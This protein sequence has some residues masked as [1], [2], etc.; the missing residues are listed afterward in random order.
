[1]SIKSVI[2]S[3][4][5]KVKSG[6]SAK[7]SSLIST[8]EPPKEKVGILTRIGNVLSAFEPGAEI[9]TFIKTGDLG[10]TAK[11]YASET[12]RGLGSA[13]PFL[14][15]YTKPNEV[16]RNREGFREVLNALGMSKKGPWDDILGIAGDIVLDPGNLLLA[17]LFKTGA[18][19]L[20][21]A[22]KGLR[23][24]AE[25]FDVGRK[26]LGTGDEIAETIGRA[27]IPG[28]K[29]PE[30]YK[31]VKQVYK[32]LYE[33]EKKK[34]IDQ[35]VAFAKKLPDEKSFKNI[36]D[37][38]ETGGKTPIDEN[39]KPIAEEIKS[40]LL[41]IKQAEKSKG[42]LKKDIEYYFP[43]ILKDKEIVSGYKPL[44]TYLGAAKKRTKE[45]LLTEINEAMGKE[46]FE[47]NPAVAATLRGMASKKAISSRDFLETVEKSF[48][49]KGK[50][51]KLIDGVEYVPF[52]P[53][54][55]F[56]FYPVT[57]EAGKKVAGITKK[58]KTFL[59]PR[60]VADDMNKLMKSVNSPDEVNAMASLF[61]KVQNI[62]KTSVTSY[63]P[64]FHIR[65]A[66]SNMFVNWLAGVKDPMEYKKAF[67]VINGL[68]EEIA[69][70]KSGEVLDLAK[71]Y[72]VLGQG[73]FEKDL[74]DLFA[75]ELGKQGKVAEL[76]DL[77]RKAGT[78]IENN[79]RM[80]LFV[81]QLEK[82]IDPEKAAQTVKKYLFDYS[83][84]TDFEKS[85]M[86]RVFPF[87][88]WTRKAF[89]LMLDELVKQ[90][91][92]F[93]AVYD[94][95]RNLQ[96]NDLTEEEKMLI[97]EYMKNT[98]NIQIGRTDA[99]EPKFLSS[100][101]L[102][103][104]VLAKPGMT[105][106]TITQ[107]LS[108][109]LK[110]PLEQ[111]TGTSFFTKKKIKEDPFFYKTTQFM[112]NI[113]VLKQYLQAEE[114]E[115][116][117]VVNPQRMYWLKSIIGRFISTGETITKEDKEWIEKVINVLSGIKTYSFDAEEQRYFKEKEIESEQAQKLLRK[118]EISKFER[119]FVPKD[120]R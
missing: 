105:G 31:N 48:G 108:P 86:R 41:E 51:I 79:A 24:V 23:G 42:I 25:N 73:F 102:P 68:P 49:I 88:T 107:M 17:G 75:K 22:G 2:T 87:Y 104:E 103:M 92:K 20:K 50:D 82:G 36:V 47:S 69:G 35:G 1:M 46:F 67:N 101:G 99:G 19:G 14:D 3:S 93:K 117:W 61:D 98:F 9:K 43:H 64:S 32:D 33:Y 55:A 114:G 59:L 11:Q 80:T 39:I 4:K 71:R 89:P 100:L 90:P 40:Y 57:T 60:E 56:K 12:A 81:N 7:T 45:G 83:D 112:A 27:F 63:F 113:P 62:W 38:I 37:W 29:L 54:G 97:P 72:G 76:L 110:I 96:S 119:Y 18:K 53:E 21:Y 16:E 66:T 15:E 58:T 91:K 44:N 52:K 84:L 30:N 34:V 13:I 70:K 5:T 65:N 28:Y 118:G 120:K 95:M 10:K 77:G 85:V 115:K 8:Q 106:D 26:L 116:G 111:A 109:L 74:T 6:S 94:V 78:G